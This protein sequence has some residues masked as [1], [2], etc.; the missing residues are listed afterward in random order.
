M[1]LLSDP[2]AV[3]EKG[4]DDGQTDPIERVLTAPLPVLDRNK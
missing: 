4:T 1:E 2:E 3:G